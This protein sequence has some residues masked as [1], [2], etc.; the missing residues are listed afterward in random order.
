MKK[1]IVMFQGSE[2]K[3]EEIE[4]ICG[5]RA[6][7]VIL[8]PA[9]TMAAATSTAPVMSSSSGEYSVVARLFPVLSPEL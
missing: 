6:E 3:R 1:V 7:A 8:P 4:A 2:E 5:E 9:G